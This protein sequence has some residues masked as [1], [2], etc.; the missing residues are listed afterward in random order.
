MKIGAA[1]V[2]KPA[3]RPPDSVSRITIVRS[4]PGLIPSTNP[5]VAPAIARPNIR[6]VSN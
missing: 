1:A 5:K 2:H 3:R 6:S 4:G